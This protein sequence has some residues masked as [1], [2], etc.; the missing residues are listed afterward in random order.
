MKTARITKSA[1]IEHGT[2]TGNNEERWRLWS[3]SI[4]HTTRLVTSGMQIFSF[5]K[6]SITDEQN[7]ECDVFVSLIKDTQVWERNGKKKKD[8]ECIVVDDTKNL[9]Y[10][11]TDAMTRDRRLQNITIWLTQD[12][13]YGNM[14]YIN[15]MLEEILL[16][17]KNM[18]YYG[19]NYNFVQISCIVLFYEI[20]E[21]IYFSSSKIS[22][23]TLYLFTISFKSN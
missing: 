4:C 3:R 9:D 18:E 14:C 12:E 22:A 2:Q 7:R 6:L 13:H 16:R 21:E 17:S 5:C 15:S 8:F 10:M 19:C 20:F 23:R 11:K 1:N